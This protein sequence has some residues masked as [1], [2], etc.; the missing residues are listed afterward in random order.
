MTPLRM[1][2]LEPYMPEGKTRIG[3]LLRALLLSEKKC[4]PIQSSATTRS[5][6][7]PAPHR[8]LAARSAQLLRSSTR[9]R[10]SED[11]MLA[12]PLAGFECDAASICRETNF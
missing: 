8:R 11:R 4:C 10:D 5:G 9:N 2:F 7:V 1:A 6:V 3:P 12:T